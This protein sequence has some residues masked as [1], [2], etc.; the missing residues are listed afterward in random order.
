MFTLHAIEGF[1]HE[2]IAE[3][4]SIQI[5]TS[6]SNLH[7]AKRKLRVH[8]QELFESKHDERRLHN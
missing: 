6:K 1:T 5:G 2:E 8:L 7:R 3:K 4:L